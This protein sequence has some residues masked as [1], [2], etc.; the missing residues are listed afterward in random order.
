LSQSIAWARA[1]DAA[2]GRAFAVF[3]PDEGVGG[4]VFATADPATRTLAFECVNGPI[5]DW[6]SDQAAPRQ[7]A[8][9]ATAVARLHPRFGTLKMRPRWLA[10][11]S[12]SRLQSLPIPAAGTSHAATLKLSLDARVEERFSPRLR[13]TL[14]ASERA[15]ATAWWEDLAP[16]QV[17]DFAP[18]MAYFAR[19]KGF[20]VPP[21]TWFLALTQSASECERLRFGLARAQADG[22]EC[23]LL[24]AF[25]GNEAHYLFGHESRATG[26]RAAI[27]PSALA[28]RLAI[29]KALELGMTAYDFNGF[30][31]D[32]SPEHPYAGVC[33]FKAQFGGELVRYEVPELWVTNEN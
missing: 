5:L 22:A 33:R 11:D 10:A 31:E 13:R 30:L 21:V 2:S 3:S 19:A 24:I 23:Q 9:F 14:T 7:L 1:I 26:T 32:A 28:H 6:D 27:S 18:R 20:S 15:G 12:P 25:H 17:A 16:S 4:I 8:T 29:R